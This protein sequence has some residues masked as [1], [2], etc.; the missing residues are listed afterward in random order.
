MKKLKITIEFKK[1]PNHG[2]ARDYEDGSYLITIN[3][4]DSPGVKIDTLFHEFGH[5]IY[6]L[7]AS[8]DGDKDRQE[9]FADSVGKSGRRAFRKYWGGR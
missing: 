4:D 8:V 6:W 2:E 5:I 7:F 3:K 1:T 9:K